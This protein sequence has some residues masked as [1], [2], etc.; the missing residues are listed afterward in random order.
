MNRWTVRIW[1]GAGLVVLGLLMLLERFGLFHGATNLFWGLVFLAGGAWF[2][3]RFWFNMRGEWWAAIP[4]FALAGI[5]AESMLSNVLG[6]WSGFFF[7]GALGLGFF[8]I[9]FSDRERWWAIIPGGVLV[10][11]GLV[12][13]AAEVFGGRETGG[14]LMAGLGLTFLLVAILASL[15]WAWIPGLVLLVIGVL[16]GG[17]QEGAMNYVWP[18]ALIVGGLLLIFQFA[19]RPR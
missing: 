16:I 18:I 1:I 5:G 13:V 12:S 14:L 8:A 17:L 3:Y 11:L 2:L 15:Q 19:R 6:A 7:L 9:Y 4:G 10:T